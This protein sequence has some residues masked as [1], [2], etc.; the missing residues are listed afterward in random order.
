MKKYILF[1]LFS[2]TVFQVFAS[3]E[4]SDSAKSYYNQER[5]AEAAEAW[6]KLTN[7]GSQISSIYYN[8]GNAYFKNNEIALAILNYERALKLSPGDED[9]QHNLQ[10]AQSHIADKVEAIPDLFFIVWLNQ[11][12]MWQSTNT[13]AWFSIISFVFLL[14]L[15]TWRLLRRQTNKQRL[16]FIFAIIMFFLSAFSMFLALRA[17]YSFH[18][19]QEAIIMKDC[20]IKSSPSETGTNLFEVHEGL[21]IEIQDSVNNYT[22]IRLADGKKGWIDSDIPEKI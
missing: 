20:L 16:I 15:V 14:M 12:N 1:L 8:L 5:Y 17:K 7:E 13:W 6:E 21:K 2:I 22:E 10:I 4:I 18:K 19:D 3:S 9:I 11:L